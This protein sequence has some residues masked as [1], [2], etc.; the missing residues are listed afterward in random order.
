MVLEV[1]IAL[2]FFSSMSLVPIQSKQHNMCPRV[3]GNFWADHELVI[4]AF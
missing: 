1:D 2:V 4:D 3:A